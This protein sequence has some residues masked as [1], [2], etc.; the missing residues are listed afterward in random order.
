V[1]TVS[2][3]PANALS[4][5]LQGDLAEKVAAPPNSTGVLPGTWRLT[6]GLSNLPHSPGGPN[7]PTER[8]DVVWVIT[9]VLASGD[10]VAERNAVR[11]VPAVE[12]DSIDPDQGPSSGGTTITLTGHGFTGT[13]KVWFDVFANR[14]EGTSLTVLSDTK[15]TVV[16]PPGTGQANVV[17]VTPAGEVGGREFWYR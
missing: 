2:T 1:P 9:C 13:S 14:V 12:I 17:A 3:D 15:M 6:W 11:W 4:F 8:V 16:T 10:V 7:W 5:P